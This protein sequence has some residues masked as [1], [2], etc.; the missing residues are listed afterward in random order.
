M[1]VIT[2]LSIGSCGCDSFPGSG[3]ASSGSVP[4]ADGL[5]IHYQVWGKGEPTLVFVHG[6]C[7][8]GTYWRY[9]VD[10]FKQFHR[11]VTIDLAGHGLSDTGREKWTLGAF[12][13]DVVAVVDELGIEHMIL[14]GHSMGGPVILEAARRMPGRVL[15]LVGADTFN[16]FEVRYD[17]KR[18]D[19]FLAP[20]E[21]NFV[22][23]VTVFVESM[24]GTGANP[25]LVD[26]VIRDMSSAPPDVALGSLREYFQTDL[27]EAVEAVDVPI[28]CI[29][30]A[31]YPVKTESNR[32]HASSFEV[33]VMER[34]GHFVM[35]EDPDTFNTN[36][37]T[38]IEE[39]I[40]S[41][42]EPDRTVGS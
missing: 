40:S 25:N 4:S 29:N 30:S 38:V 5:S 3:S 17:Q 19:A 39:L 15:G 7:C 42:R 1:I 22:K 33:I 34:V 24:F 10:H 31:R 41:D 2:C 11:V 37:E 13:Q 35:L 12:G 36:L 23:A 8:D 9:Q 26:E 14:I 18:I 28:R 20:M 27:V 16:D 6:W 21:K 32:N